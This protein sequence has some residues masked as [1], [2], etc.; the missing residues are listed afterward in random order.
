MGLTLLESSQKGQPVHVGH[1]QVGQDDSRIERRQLG[2]GFAAVAGCLHHESPLPNQL[3]H[4]D[5]RRLVVF[6]NQHALAVGLSRILVRHR[7]RSLSIQR[8]IL[9]PPDRRRRGRASLRT[10]SFANPY[11]LLLSCLSPLV[12]SPSSLSLPQGP[13][14]PG[15]IPGY[16]G[17]ICALGDGL[18]IRKT[19]FRGLG[20]R[21]RITRRSSKLC[22]SMFCARRRP[23]GVSGAFVCACPAGCGRRETG[24]V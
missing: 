21:A 17:T 22:R 8:E 6:D 16:L 14:D 24:A 15:G 11:Y 19:R 5:T 12:A 23:R 3:L 4:A 10:Q 18:N 9:Q 20:G 2:Q 7:Q 1:L 13:R